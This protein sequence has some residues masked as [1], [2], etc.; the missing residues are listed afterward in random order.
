[1]IDNIENIYFNF[2]A[3]YENSPEFAID[4]Y[5]KNL[6]YFN[7]VKHFKDKNEITLYTELICK[8]AEAIYLKNRYNLAIDVINKKQLFI[9]NEIQRLN[10]DK[11]KGEWYY[12]LQFVKGMAS[13]NLKDYKTATPIFKSLV[14]IDNQNDLYKRWLTYSNYGSNLWLVRLVNIFCVVLI[15]TEIVFESQ[16]NNFLSLTLLIIGLL[17]LFTNWAYEYYIGRNF[18]K[19]KA[20]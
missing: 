16:I 2:K 8:Y 19:T 5:E 11:I 9:D 18:R 12:C 15:V 13:Y 17:G 14:Q 7:N 3:N 10:A 20:S 4:F 1:M 6:I